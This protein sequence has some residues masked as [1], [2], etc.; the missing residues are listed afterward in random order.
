MVS[1]PPVTHTDGAPGTYPSLPNNRRD[2]GCGK[3]GKLLLHGG[4][5]SRPLPGNMG[6]DVP[7]P[8]P[9]E[10]GSL[11]AWP[12]GRCAGDSLIGLSIFSTLRRAGCGDG[13]AQS[14]CRRG[15]G[16]VRLDQLPE[17][18]FAPPDRPFG[19]LAYGCS[20]LLLLL[21]R[22]CAERSKNY[23]GLLG[24][25]VVQPGSYAELLPAAVFCS[26]PEPVSW[27]Q[28]GVYRAYQI[29]EVLRAC[30]I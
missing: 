8:R 1:I 18:G 20:A 11:P 13:S 16:F 22:S 26:P 19:V 3:L 12:N 15:D 24:N 10:P 17:G 14:G 9:G 28:E 25:S 5:F 27:L 30:R 6:S 2:G 7:F 29:S 23:A 4:R 21:P